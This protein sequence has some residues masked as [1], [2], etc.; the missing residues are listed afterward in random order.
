MDAPERGALMLVRFFAATLVGWTLV[1]G[2]LYWVVR[3]HN[4]QPVE[5]LTLLFKALPLLLGVVMFIKAKPVA[6]WIS[7]MLDL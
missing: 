5:I 4:D 6:A 3:M 7:D 2:S 1:D